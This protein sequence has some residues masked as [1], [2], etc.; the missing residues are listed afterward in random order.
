MRHAGKRNAL[1]DEEAAREQSL[2]TGA[3][4]RRTGLL[5]HRVFEPIGCTVVRTDL[6]DLEALAFAITPRTKLVW[7]E[8]P[9]NPRLLV[10]DIAAIARIAHE[11]GALCVVDNTF[12]TPY[13]QRP[14][15]LGADIVIHSV[16]KYLA[17]HSDLIQG[18]VLAKDPAIFEPI[19]FLQNV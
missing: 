12:A 15:E 16:T 11:R 14:F 13:F 7:L 17:G 6:A 8:S 10:Y 9:T 3:S 5:L 1:A 18:A 2:M 19:A 4:V